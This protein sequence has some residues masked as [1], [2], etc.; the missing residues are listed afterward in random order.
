MPT[1]KWVATVDTDS[2]HPHEGLFDED[3]ATIARQLA[4]KK[5]SPKGP[6]SGMRM[7]NYYINRAGKNLPKERHTELEKAKSLLSE[8]IAKQKEKS[9]KT[10]L[11]KP[12]KKATTKTSRKA[13]R[14]SPAKAAKRTSSA[15]R[16]TRQT[17]L[18]KTSTK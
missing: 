16:T 6:S 7:L 12:A 10:K 14:K 17:T 5:V 13:A 15:K 18:K 1:K 9:P 4:S 2:T 11:R 3:A 8:I